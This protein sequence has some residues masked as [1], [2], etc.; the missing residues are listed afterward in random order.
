MHCEVGGTSALPKREGCL[1]SQLEVFE[2]NSASNGAACIVC[3]KP[4]LLET[5]RKNTSQCLELGNTFRQV[6]KIDTFAPVTMFRGSIIF[7][8]SN[9]ASILFGKLANSAKEIVVDPISFD[10]RCYRLTFIVHLD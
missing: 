9:T 7:A 4:L 8:L 1:F 2:A 10:Q 6:V 3:V 5:A